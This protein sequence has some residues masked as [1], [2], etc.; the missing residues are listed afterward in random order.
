MKHK[1][2]PP[3]RRQLD[4]LLRSWGSKALPPANGWLSELRRGF[5]LARNQVAQRLGVSPATI[6]DL[7]RGEAAGTIT[8][9]SLR[10]AAG[11]MDCDLVYAIVPRAGTVDEQ[12]KQ[13]ARTV[14]RRIVK[15]VTH[16][17]ALESQAPEPELVQQQ[18][19]DLADELVRTLAPEL[20]KGLE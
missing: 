15:G 5:G 2:S 4:N 3:R 10:R 14:A 16:T 20:W 8:L 18:I 7:E 9:N 17:M 13:R 12:L 19:E 1:L 6:A 11:A